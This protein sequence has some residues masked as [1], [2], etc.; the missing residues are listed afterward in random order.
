MLTGEDDEN[1]CA[2]LKATA[3]ERCR[4]RS[5]PG[6][7]SGSTQPGA[8]LSRK[9]LAV[10][11][12]PHG[13]TARPQEGGGRAHRLPCPTSPPTVGSVSLRRVQPF[14]NGHWASPRRRSTSSICTERLH[15]SES[16][17]G[18]CGERERSQDV[19]MLLLR[20]VG[21]SAFS[22][23]HLFLRLGGRASCSSHG[24]RLPPFLCATFS[25]GGRSMRLLFN[26]SQVAT[27]ALL[28]M[29]RAPVRRPFASGCA[30]RGNGPC[31]YCRQSR[32]ARGRR[33]TISWPGAW[34]LVG[35][36]LA[37]CWLVLHPRTAQESG[38][39]HGLRTA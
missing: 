22:P 24:A 19:R 34:A 27:S 23:S 6:R 28:A 11:V 18:K 31:C 15:A 4:R 38:P 8:K 1:D 32:V 25:A 13:P 16:L 14:Q 2:C 5:T 10:T 9:E 36:R 30:P 12:R 33:G 7:S 17:G 39:E 35:V 26:P 21:F 37:G 20:L 29:A 3:R